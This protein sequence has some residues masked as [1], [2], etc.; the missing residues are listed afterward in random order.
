MALTSFMQKLRSKIQL[1]EISADDAEA[2]L[3]LQPSK[4]L[5]DETYSFGERMVDEVLDRTAQIDAKATS[6]LGWSAGVLAF[7]T[8]DS[9]GSWESW[10]VGFVT[11]TALVLSM[12]AA[13]RAGLALKVDDWSISSE[14]DWF[15]G[16]LFA[17]PTKLRVYHVLGMLETHQRHNRQNMIKG[18]HARV[19]QLCLLLAVICLGVLVVVR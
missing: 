8:F 1:N 17:D 2:L 6:L 7:L 3:T 18:E 19:S 4:E 9:R 15:R 12:I 14:R 10:L 16:E 5:L 11:A 13:M